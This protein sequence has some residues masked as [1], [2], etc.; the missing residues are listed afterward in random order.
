MNL[1]S[2]IAAVAS[3]PEM[4][5]NYIK[6][7]GSRIL[8]GKQPRITLAGRS[9]T[10]I[11]E[12]LSFSEYW[13]FKDIVPVR[14]QLF[15]ESCLAACVKSGGVAFDVGANI[16]AFSLLIASMDCTVHAFEPI[17]ETFCRLK[18][19]MRFNGALDNIHLS[20]LAV[21]ADQGLVRFTIQDNS[22][23][24]NRMAVPGEVTKYNLSYSQVVG[25]V[26]LD[27]YCKE[28]GLDNISF[29][30]IDVEGMEP[31]VLKGARDLLLARKIAAILIEIC[32]ENLLAVGLTCADLYREFETVG[33]FPYL[34]NPDGTP[35]KRLSLADIESVRLANA[36]LLPDA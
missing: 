26:S 13:S 22:P 11:G 24:T 4:L 10:S 25:A 17:P 12:W 35:G 9:D 5:S 2:K 28:Q 1:T 18:K 30:K 34:L 3:N 23:A 8:T 27:H 32:P 19:N 15:V 21:G 7:I 20:C 14:E 16:G 36:A 29:L 33:Y 6:W 31:Y